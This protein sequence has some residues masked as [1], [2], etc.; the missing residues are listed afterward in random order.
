MV[1]TATN[2]HGET[3]AIADS[4]GRV[5]LNYT[6]PHSAAPQAGNPPP[7]V[8]LRVGAHEVSVS[9]LLGADLLHPELARAAMLTGAELIIAPATSGFTGPLGPAAPKTLVDWRSSENIAATLAVLP[10][11]A[12]ESSVGC[13]STGAGLDAD[14]VLTVDL[15]ELR[16]SRRGSSGGDA[17]RRPFSYHPLCGLAP[18]DA[19]PPPPPSPSPQSLRIAMLQMNAN[20]SSLAQNQAKAEAY[21]RRA[22]AAGADVALMPEMWSVGYDDQFP[23]FP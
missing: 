18:A 4:S 13:N 17:Y 8:A 7:A 2:E 3:L 19:T 9:A 6:K 21:C 5:V 15:E 10:L 14:G 20:R 16:E 23:C 12:A 1:C 22:A 11:G